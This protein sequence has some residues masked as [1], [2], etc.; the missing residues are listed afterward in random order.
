MEEYFCPRCEGRAFV[1]QYDAGNRA[2]VYCDSCSTYDITRPG[3][4]ELID[5]S[6]QE[7]QKKNSIAPEGKIVEFRRGMSV[8]KKVAPIVDR[9][10]PDWFQLTCQ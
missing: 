3:F 1:S 7:R 9:P 6:V 8:T 2:R 10:R 5:K 4:K